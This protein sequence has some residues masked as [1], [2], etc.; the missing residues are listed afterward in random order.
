MFKYVI[1]SWFFDLTEKHG[2]K[3]VWLKKQINNIICIRILTNFKALTKYVSAKCILIY[4]PDVRIKTLL[5]ASKY[6]KTFAPYKTALYLHMLLHF[7]H[8]YLLYTYNRNRNQICKKCTWNWQQKL[9]IEY[10]FGKTKH[11]IINNLSWIIKM[12]K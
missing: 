6:L 1:K 3:L 2:Q 8:F 5:L 10:L 4:L 9:K 12:Q 11:N 7:H